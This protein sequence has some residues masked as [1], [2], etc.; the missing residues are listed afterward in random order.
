VAFTYI[1]PTEIDVVIPAGTAATTT[2]IS[3][4]QP[5]TRR[6]AHANYTYDFP[7]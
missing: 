5:N 1:S 3:V 6:G 7:F 4:L 2:T